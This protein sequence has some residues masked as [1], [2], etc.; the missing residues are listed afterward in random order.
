M[1][2][3]NQAAVTAG[4]SCQPMRVIGFYRH[5]G[6]AEFSESGDAVVSGM[7]LDR[8]NPSRSAGMSRLTSA[9][10]LRRNGCMLGEW[11]RTWRRP[12]RA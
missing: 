2:W 4:L 5:V 1:S 8:Q 12:G 3:L 7:D 6:F 9:M 11:L 10:N